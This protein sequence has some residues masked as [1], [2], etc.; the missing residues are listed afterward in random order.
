MIFVVVSRERRPPV[1][2]VADHTCLP[3]SENLV[4]A[5]LAEFRVD[6][7]AGFDKEM[8][9]VA[10]G[11]TVFVTVEAMTPVFSERGG[12]GGRREEAAPDGRVVCLKRGTNSGNFCTVFFF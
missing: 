6:T 11:V 8:F 3:P 2:A 10:Q 7:A 12:A 4:I 9:T 5:E 1:A